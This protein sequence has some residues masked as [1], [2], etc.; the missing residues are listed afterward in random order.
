VRLIPAD[1]AVLDAA[2]EGHRA[3]ACAIGCEVPADWNVFP[4]ALRA[5][6]DAVATDP[7]SGRWGT[8]LF[9]LDEPPTLV[10][11]GGFKGPPREGV[12]EVGYAVAPSWERRGLATAAVGELVGEAFSAP[13]VRTVVAHTVAEPG[14]SPRVLKKAGF[15]LEAEVPDDEA[16][17]AWRF[18]LDRPERPRP[19]R[20]RARR[21]AEYGHQLD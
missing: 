14:P 10:G 2:I 9:V 4:E 17:T 18:R 12:V 13:E 6:R 7:A 20:A 19:R 15:S 8:R 5:I 11:W 3:L 21:P 16:G 1:V